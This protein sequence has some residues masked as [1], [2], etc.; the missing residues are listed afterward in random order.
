MIGVEQAKHGISE[1][2]QRRYA[3]VPQM[4]DYDRLEEL[5]WLPYLMTFHPPHLSTPSFTTDADGFRHTWWQGRPLT[6]SGYNASGL[7]R[8]ALIGSSAAFGVG[9]S[10]DA[11]T[12][13]SLWNEAGGRIC[14]NFAGRGFNSTQELLAFLLYLPRDVD[15]L[16]L[17]SGVNNLVLS[18]LS[19]E[20]SPVYNSFYA[21]GAFERGLRSGLVTGIRGGLRLLAQELVRK[22]SPEN[23]LSARTVSEEERYEQVLACSRRDLRLWSLLRDGLRC[24]LYFV[25]QPIAAWIPKRLSP[26]E[27]ELSGILDQ[28]DPTGS[29][30]N[31][32]QHLVRFKDRYR[33]DVQALCDEFGIPFLDLNASA[34]LTSDRWLFVDRVHLTDEGYRVC[35]QEIAGA[36]FS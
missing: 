24:K 6:L 20:T 36:V 26:E 18:T 19:S 21:Q 1:L 23:G 16:V 11:G 29:W 10:S 22:I 13:A 3:L 27:Q 28:I 35:A 9:A 14:F 25:F 12:L 32:L 17:V 31:A 2:R 8:V 4:R 5:E 30:G 15:A 7:P 33:S 34:E